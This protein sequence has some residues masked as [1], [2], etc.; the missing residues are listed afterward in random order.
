GFELVRRRVERVAVGDDALREHGVRAVGR[1]ELRQVD[2][3]RARRTGAVDVAKLHDAL[4]AEGLVHL[5]LAVERFGADGV[6]RQ[7]AAFAEH[8]GLAVR[9]EAITR[10]LTREERRARRI[11]DLPAASRARARLGRALDGR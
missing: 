1:G 2:L 7:L 9:I 3:D 8:T 11:G 6:H 5:A 4:Q 10:R